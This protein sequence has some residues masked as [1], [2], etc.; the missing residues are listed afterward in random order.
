MR[1]QHEGPEAC[2]GS[3][4]SSL[5]APSFHYETK[6]AGKTEFPL[7]FG[8]LQQGEVLWQGTHLNKRTWRQIPLWGAQAVPN[9]RHPVSATA[10]LSPPSL[11]HQGSPA[12]KGRGRGEQLQQWPGIQPQAIPAPPSATVPTPPNLFLF[13]ICTLLLN[14]SQALN[15]FYATHL[16]NAAAVPLFHDFCFFKCF[17]AYLTLK[18]LNFSFS[19][20]SSLLDPCT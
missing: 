11:L 15:A 3:S 13:R 7:W 20:N 6:G 12:K 2:R 17:T 19:T 5:C 10:A 4:A 16:L 8:F 18:L 1:G 9:C 14:H